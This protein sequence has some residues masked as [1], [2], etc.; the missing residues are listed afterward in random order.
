MQ[1]LCLSA[2]NRGLEFVESNWDFEVKKR[3]T[4]HDGEQSWNR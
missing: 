2:R 3:R 1:L 4:A